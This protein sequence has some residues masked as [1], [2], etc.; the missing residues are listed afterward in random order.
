MTKTGMTFHMSAS[1]RNKP[2]PDSS[3]SQITKKKP[4]SL[5]INLFEDVRH[6]IE[7]TRDK[8]ASS[9]NAKITFL[10]WQIG[11]RI[12]TEI[13]KGDRADYGK[14]ILATLSQ[15]LTQEFVPDLVTRH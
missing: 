2:Q 3:K 10:Y 14:E 11:Q 7:K 4:G 12:Q 15:Q 13:L 8:V 5:S 1:F 9:V 6:L